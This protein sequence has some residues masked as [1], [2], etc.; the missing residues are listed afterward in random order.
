MKEQNR[1]N[2]TAD[3]LKLW[4]ALKPQIESLIDERTKNC[5]RVKR[6]TVATAP[7]ATAGTVG[8]QFPF[9]SNVYNLPYSSAVANVTAGTQVWV[10]IPYDNTLTNGVVVNNG[11][12]TL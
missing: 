10:L 5:V 2:G 12:W 6:G 11:G 8:I 3:V 4:E 9:D 1:N 7:N